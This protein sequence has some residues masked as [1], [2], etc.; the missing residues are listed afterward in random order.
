LFD[1]ASKYSELSP[2]HSFT[3]DDPNR[4][5]NKMKDLDELICWSH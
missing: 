1:D 2:T 5:Y 4:T 3:N